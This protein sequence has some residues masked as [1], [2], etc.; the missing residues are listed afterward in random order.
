MFDPTLIPPPNEQ[1]DRV[2]NSTLVGSQASKE[3]LEVS[4]IFS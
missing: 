1:I 4:D 3:S 2:I